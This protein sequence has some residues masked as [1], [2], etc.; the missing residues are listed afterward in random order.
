MVRKQGQSHERYICRVNMASLM[1]DRYGAPTGTIS[2][3]LTG[4]VSREIEMVCLR[5]RS[6]GTGDRD[7]VLTAVS[8][9]IVM[10]R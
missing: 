2:R 4:T 9:E 1:R 10:V 5:R 8:R 6:R 7:G 3:A